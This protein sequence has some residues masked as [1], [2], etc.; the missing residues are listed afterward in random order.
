VP[1]PQWVLRMCLSAW[2]A[3][4]AVLA[5]VPASSAVE[6]EGECASAPNPIVCEN[7][8]P[9]DP[10]KNWQVEGVG[11]PTIQ[12]FATSMSVNVGQTESFKINTPASSYHT[13]ILRLGYYG[14]NGARVIASNV[15]PT[16]ELPQNQPECLKEPST[17]LIDCGNWGVSASWTVPSNAVSGVYIALL[18]RNDT[19]GKSQIPFVVR[20]DSSHSEILLQTSDATWEAYNDYGGNSLYTCTVACP[21]GNPQAYK[22]AYAVSYNRPFDGSFT[23]D[24]G[25]SYLYYAEYQMMRWLEKNGYNV[26]YTSEAEVDNSG[27]LLKNHKLF[28]SS[29]HDEYWSAGQ[30]A[31]VLAA[32]EAGVNLTFFSGNEMFW[33]TRWAPSSEGSN[34]PYRTLITY[35]ETHFNAPV[36]P[37]DPTVWT[38]AW[39]DP[40]FSPPADGG[41]PENALTGQQFEV[42]SGT[43]DITVPSQYGKLRLW[44]STAVGALEP[45]QSLTLSPGTGTLGYE[46]DE[47]VDNGFRP[48]GE[49]DLS[50]TTVSGVQ[51]F[52]DYGTTLSNN[53]TATHHL[54]LY[55]APSKALVFGAGTVQWSWGLENVNAWGAEFTDPSQNPPDPNMEQFTVNLLAEM[56]AQPATLSSGLVAAS[57]STD[58]TAPTSTIT[59]P[60]AGETFEDSHR[61]TISGTAGDT[62]GSVVAGVEVST[63]GGSTWHPATI[64]TPAEVSV[65]WSYTWLAHGSPSTRIRSRAVDDSANLE[66]PF[67]GV[68]VNVSCPCSIWGANLTPP[69]PDAGDPRSAELGVKFTSETFGA[70]TGIRFYK[71]STNTGMH[72]GN[73]WSASGQRLATATFTSETESGWQQVN[74]SNPVYVYPNT[75]YVASYFDPAG[76]YAASQYYFY[77]PPAT[78]GNAL[79]SPPLHAIPA[80]ATSGDG[81]YAYSA[82]SAFPSSSYQGTNYWVDPVFVPAPAPGQVTSVSGTAGHGSVTLSWSAP[83]TGGLPTT[84][85]ITPYIGF[86]PQQ[87]TTVTGTPPEV[88]TKIT[89]LTPGTEYTFTVQASNPNGAGPVSEPSSAVVP[90]ELT[91]PTAPTNVVASAA[92][93]QALVSWSPPGNDGGGSLTGYT[94]TPYIGGVAQTPVEVSPSSTSTI[95]AGLANGTTYTFRVTAANAYGTSLPSGSSNEVTPRDTIFDFATPATIDSKDTG[96][97]ELGVK[98]TA[99]A[100]GTITGIRFYKAATNIGTHVGS[101]WTSTGTLLASATFSNETASGWQRVNFPAPVAIN[102]STTYIAGYFAPKGH[103]SDTSS[104]F[105]SAGV[106]NPP[107]QAL[108]NA[109]SADGVYKYAS[110][111]A[112]PTSTYKATN[113]WIDVDFVATSPPGQ[114][115]NVSATAGPGSATLTWNAPSSGGPVT[116]YTITPYI[117]SEAQPASTVTGSPPRTTATLQGLTN[118]TTYTFTV[119][120]SNANGAGPAS[121]ASNPVIPAAPTVP[122]APSN[123]VASAA[124]NQALVS[125]SVPAN[126]GGTLI[127][128][129]T[130]TPYAG[131]TALTPI[132]VP[133][134]TTSTIVKGLTNG[135]GYTFKVSATNAV[136]TGPSSPASGEAVPTYTIFDFGTPT[137]VDSA[138]TSS[139]EV[140]VQFN[141]EVAGMITGIRFY[142]AA[143][144]TGTHV[145]SLWSSAGALLTQATFTNETGSGWQQVNFATPVAIS[146]NTTYVAAYLVPNGHYSET[147]S[148]FA[149]AAVSNPP[150]QALPNPIAP[151]GV[152]TRTSTS[153]FPTST[154]NAANYRVDVDFVPTPAPGLVTGVSATAGTL[155]ATV[156]WSAPSG[157]GPVTT[158]KITPY[159]GSEAQPAT[160]IN[161]APPATEATI[162]GLAGGTGYTFTVQA[163]NTAGAGPASEPS[164]SVTPTGP[165]VPSSPTGVTASAATKQA[166]VSWNA[167]ANEGGSPLTGY[168][169]TPFIGASAQTP[170]HVSPSTTS[171]TLTGLSNGTSYTFAVT[172]S[173][174]VGES[175]LSSASNSVTP[176]D[177]IFDFATPV[178]IDSGDGSSVELGVKFSSELYGTVSGIRFYKAS[179]NTGTHVGSLWSSTGALLAQATF[180]NETASGWQQVNFSTPVVINP[181][182]TYV[183]GY[184]APKGH[185]SDT[186]SA[187]ASIGVGNP[188]LQ[189]LANTTSLNGVYVYTATSAFPTSSVKATDYWVDLDFLPAPSPGQVTNVS[190]TAGI[191]SANLT[192]SAPASGGPVTTY[193]IT[194]YVG[195]EAQ[196]ATTINGA[197]PATGVTIK[198]LTIGTSYT[199]TVQASNPNGAGPSSEPSNAVTPISGIVPPSAPTE[200]LGSPAAQQAQLNWTAPSTNGGGTITGYLVTPY[201]GSSA[202][203]PIEF[204]AS[205]TSAVVKGL[206]NA[207]SYTFTVA[208]VNSAGVGAASTASNAVTPRDTIFDFSTPATIDSGDGS[209]VVLGVKFSSEVAGT[210]TGIRFYKATTN[211]GTHIGSLW[212]ATGTLLAS[213]TFAN[214]TASGWQ[215]MYFSTPVA[216]TANTTYVVSYLS[217]KGHYSDTSSA[218]ASIGV[219]NPPLQALASTT[220]LNG[221]YKYT[222]SNAFPNSSY[223]ATNYWVDVDFEPSH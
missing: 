184:L 105:A 96:S 83:S 190:A 128:G 129:Y 155:S 36:D 10:A 40:R 37:Q 85:T 106:S 97:V 209:S 102:A 161:G 66:T 12:G 141:S 179:A 53:S 17:G 198:G 73:L 84:Y 30:R 94:V 48:A 88:T 26:S 170:V 208:A 116:T 91:P 119:Q 65:K 132:E 156:K 194:P 67:G 74:F 2:L 151:D 137:I 192:W 165:T 76:H 115:S 33:K 216:I 64:A 123:V 117:G 175:A 56:G 57:Q 90:T 174:E 70:I 79:N 197:P 148:A 217:P 104:G 32:R 173:N 110:A 181:N 206:T 19:G 144:N 3:L 172:A 133:E 14:G 164:N 135:T 101:L 27:A 203:T 47:D 146:P 214:E 182:T 87:T 221:V 125:W 183:A 150:L 205:K 163:S 25:N 210:V 13:E 211:T 29:G 108:A 188:P 199:F 86:V 75:T 81:V 62:G 45:G 11:D 22:A 187:F 169:V 149:T 120:A 54:T 50:S 24:R 171:T 180:T 99:E 89:G 34:T 118:G 68:A 18:T 20:N 176:Q 38:G 80:S 168:T 202:Q 213:A 7:A 189:A 131:A 4:I 52:T 114:V 109:T 127:T 78:G 111:S 92:T 196:L 193:T 5:I 31:N 200:V 77:T 122:A 153:A 55:R 107:L 158:Y 9:G 63:D 71:A 39:R 223:K 6:G 23:T 95:V 58:P 49:F 72:I 21:P 42:N 157:G 167:P 103:Y 218:F 212:S 98:F 16:A 139:T 43:S 177:T 207:T 61:V 46:W 185:Y 60:A 152:Y 222:S 166:L 130:V 143:T 126:E 93:R 159:V 160:T 113:Y 145:G 191:G 154:S 140:G 219:S 69:A 215:Q 1:R 178:T 201:V 220:S 138:N 142:K 100:A 15:Q 44:R 82:S 186:S 51:A 204:P 8:L 162:K 35:K 41:Q 59:S 147:P 124:T 195:S 121:S 112:F 28:M 136:G 134:S